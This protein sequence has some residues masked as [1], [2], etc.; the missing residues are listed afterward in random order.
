M[1][2]YINLKVQPFS[3][4]ERHNLENH[5]QLLVLKTFNKK[6]FQLIRVTQKTPVDLY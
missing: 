1:K 4:K 6:N 2:L 3:V 5:I